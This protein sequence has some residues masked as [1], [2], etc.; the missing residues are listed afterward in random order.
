MNL[1][2]V[3]KRLALAGAFV[4]GSLLSACGITPTTKFDFLATDSAPEG[5][6]M[7]IIRGSF[8]APDGYSLSMPSSRRLHHGWGRMVSSEV[9]GPDLKSLPNRMEIEFFSYTEN[10]FYKGEFELPYDT[11]V[12]LFNEGY[13]SPKKKGHTTYHDIMT[14]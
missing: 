13:Y 2:T 6:P 12:R 10:V 7:K 11:I 1:K 8:I 9:G 4:F 14:S 3:K 5:F